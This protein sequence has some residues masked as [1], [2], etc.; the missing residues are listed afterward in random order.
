MVGKNKEHWVN[1]SQWWMTVHGESELES[2]EVRW[3]SC[4][5][6]G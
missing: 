4:Q 2:G 5:M 3:G 1:Q 6:R